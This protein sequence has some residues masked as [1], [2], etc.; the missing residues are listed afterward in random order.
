MDNKKIKEL[1]EKQLELL[2]KQSECQA[3]D[4]SNISEMSHA[5]VEVVTLLRTLEKSR[6]PLVSTP[7]KDGKSI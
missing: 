1:L 7:R 3:L 2:S 4:G 5:M 6:P